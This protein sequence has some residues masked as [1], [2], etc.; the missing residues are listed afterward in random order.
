MNNGPLFSLVLAA[1][2]SH[3]FGSAKQLAQ[4]QGQAL[5]HRAT[6][7]AAHI[8]GPN[9]I[10]V[11]GPCWQRIVRSC[12]PFTGFFVH[13]DAHDSGL[14]SS[15][16]CG[17]KAVQGVAGAVM[18]L[19]ADQPLISTA[20]LLA[21]KEKWLESRSSIVATEFAAIAGPPAVFPANSFDSLL[22]LQ[23]DQ[24]ARAVIAKADANVI[25]V[26]FAGASVDIDTPDDL[27]NLQAPA[28]LGES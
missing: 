7:L 13:N 1:G 5:V 8:T 19:L 14:A 27:R 17:V 18:V 21:L 16:A 4:Y 26:P 20:H 25:R 6:Q 10:L 3:R 22:N 28:G 24:G 23:G 11:V 12:I 2:N 9:T 15:I